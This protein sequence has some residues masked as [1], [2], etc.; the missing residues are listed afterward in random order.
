[1]RMEE[2]TRNDWQRSRSDV[3]LPEIER[4][5]GATSIFEARVLPD[6]MIDSLL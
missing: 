5:V 3:V 1:M 4:G 2:M 6:L